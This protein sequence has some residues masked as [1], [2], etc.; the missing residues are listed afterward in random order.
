VVALAATIGYLNPLGLAVFYAPVWYLGIAAAAAE[1]YFEHHGAQPGNRKTDSVS[2]YGWLYNVLRFNHG[3]HQEH[4]YRPQVHW[5]R[6]P[7]LK[8]QLPPESERRVV[9][10][11]HWF[12]VGPRPP[13]KTVEHAA[14]PDR[15]HPQ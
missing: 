6:L 3:Y 12:N 7:A 13:L 15:E 4:H 14:Q 2:C 1:N 9:R 10:W 8:D 5:T 11:A